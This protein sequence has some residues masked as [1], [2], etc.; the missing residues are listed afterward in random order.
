[1]SA[2]G[3]LVELERA[4]IRLAR[5]GEDLIAEIRPGTS[6]EPFRERIRQQ[7][8]ALLVALLQIEIIAA[9]TV[10]PTAFNRPAYERLVALWAA[11][12]AAT[13]SA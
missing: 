11:Y 4:G 13:A 9:V 1:M 7:K 2:S 6:F 5:D 12:D 10:D 3:L 8:P